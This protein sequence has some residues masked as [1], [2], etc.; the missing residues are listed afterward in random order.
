MK[1]LGQHFLKNR[2]VISEIISA[3]AVAPG[4]IIIEIG[5]GRGAL[6][7]PL[8]KQCRSVG[9][10]AVAIEKDRKLA[11]KL[12]VGETDPNSFELVEGDALSL[13]ASEEFQKQYLRGTYKIV[14]NIPYYITGKLLRVVGSLA[15]APERCVF[16]IQKE[17][18]ERIC[19]EAPKMNR[20]AASVQFWAA[21]N[22]LAHV[23]R[24]DFF[25]APE[26]DSAVIALKT[27]SVGQLVGQ[28]GKNV[29]SS[30]V[31][32]DRYYAT[33]RTLFAQPRKT[34]L[35]N[36]ASKTESR[37]SVVNMLLLLKIDP[38][39]RPQDLTVENIEQIAE[40]FVL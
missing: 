27:R 12:A 13:L 36:L 38:K 29:V 15:P 25:P 11:E 31:A 16:M 32:A 40:K 14:G 39:S 37:E 6:T 4:E 8:V 26:V 18:A 34:I 2:A 30:E 19:A 3:I 35:N 10:R 17:V 9:A 5:P 20:L 7:A 1:F 28:T 22:I 23:P 21:P 33:V 24:Q